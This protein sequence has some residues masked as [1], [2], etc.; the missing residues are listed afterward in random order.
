MSVP[1]QDACVLKEAEDTQIINSG[2]SSND[3]MASDFITPQFHAI[4]DV[5][6]IFGLRKQL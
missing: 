2:G 1:D 4:N 6:I 5:C 3:N